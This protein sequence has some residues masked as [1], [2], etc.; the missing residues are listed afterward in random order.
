[1]PRVFFQKWDNATRPEM[2]VIAEKQVSTIEANM[3]NGEAGDPLMD[4]GE[5]LESSKVW[6]YT[7][8]PRKSTPHL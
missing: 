8:P 6:G 5:K 7:M 3:E 4:K 1:M 2:N